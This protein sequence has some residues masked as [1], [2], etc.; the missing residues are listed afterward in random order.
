MPLIGAGEQGGTSEWPRFSAWGI[1]TAPKGG[2]ADLHCHDCDEC[3]IIVQGR[4]RV[5]TEGQE[6][7]VGPGDMVV[8]RKGDAHQFVEALEDLVLVWIEDEL[9]GQK[10]PGHLHPDEQRP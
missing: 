2:S 8:T 5:T 4:A 9:R 3:W 6:Y 10:R 7:V 1:Y